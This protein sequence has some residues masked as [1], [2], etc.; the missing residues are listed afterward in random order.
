MNKGT[1]FFVVEEDAD[2][3]GY[4]ISS[5]DCNIFTQS[6][7]LNKVDAVIKDALLC[8]FDYIPQYLWKV[9]H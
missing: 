2:D 1:I 4:N 8:H 6:D 5:V 3:N 7:C 9:S